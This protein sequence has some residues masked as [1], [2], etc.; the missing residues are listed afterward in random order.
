MDHFSF[1]KKY[2]KPSRVIKVV[3]NNIWKIQGHFS[4][5]KKYLETSRAILAP[6]KKNFSLQESL[7]LRKKNV[8]IIQG[9]H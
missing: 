3:E 1:G 4:F 9:S 6:E 2:L 8:L 5:G 7:L